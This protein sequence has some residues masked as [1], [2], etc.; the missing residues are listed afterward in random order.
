MNYIR[1]IKTPSLYIV[2]FFLSICCQDLLAQETGDTIVKELNEVTVTGD[3]QKLTSSG[4][5]YYPTRKVKKASTNAIDLLQRMAINQI[6]INPVTKAITTSARDNVALFINGL[7]ATQADIEG[8]NAKDVKRVEYLDFPVDPIFRGEQHVVNIV[9]HKYE[10]GGYT[11]LYEDLETIN[12]FLDNTSLFSK[13]AYKRMTFDIYAG[14]SAR[15]SKHSGIIRNSEFSLADGVVE[16]DERFNSGIEQQHSIPVSFRAIY[17]K[18]GMQ[19]ANTV[20]FTFSEMH[21]K[22]SHGSLSF[23]PSSSATG[24][25]YDIFAPFTGRSFSWTGGYYFIFSKGWSLYAIPSAAYS[26]NDSFNT[27]KS[28]IPGSQPIVSNSEE[29]VSQFSMHINA[30]KT[31]S[32]AHSLSF[33]A[34]GSFYE[35]SSDYFGTNPSHVD[36]LNRTFSA[37]A[38]YTFNHNNRFIMNLYGGCGVTSSKVNGIK[39]SQVTP[40]SNVSFTYIP[41]GKSRF[42]LNADFGTAS[43]SSYWRSSYVRPVNELLYFSGNPDLHGYK[44]INMNFSYAWF[45]CNAFSIQ[46]FVSYMGLYD[47]IVHDYLHYDDGRSLVDIMRNNGDFNRVTAGVNLTGHLLSNSLIVQAT[48]NIRRAMSSGIYSMSKNY[49]SWSVNAQY[50]RGSWNLMA[51]FSSKEYT[52]GTITCDQQWTPAF[53]FLQIGWASGNWNITLAARNFLR[54]DYNTQRGEFKSPY[55]NERFIYQNPSYRAGVKMTATY[56]F[57]YGKR[58]NR[59]NEIGAQS[60]VESAVAK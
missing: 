25:D 21:K 48:P 58:V 10:Y 26:H 55:Y 38:N 5:V 13:F 42:Q 56:T 18:R 11:K 27:Y 59:G 47:R 4:A 19:I 39:E 40:F 20:G 41:T 45:P 51:Y 1:I 33:N 17:D 12:H 29:D 32:A 30:Y 57:G 43:V 6:I 49:F 9:M 36:N 15:S 46:S 2:L 60:G 52:M 3:N 50:Y 24:Y 7:P 22:R 53:Y 54:S 35:S 8:M 28:N 16:R 34:K 31:F 37:G 23:T 44:T 14:L